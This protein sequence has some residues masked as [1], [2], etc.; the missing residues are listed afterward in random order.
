MGVVCGLTVGLNS[1]LQR[2]VVYC[3]GDRGGRAGLGK[4]EEF[5]F[6][7]AKYERL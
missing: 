3:G 4:A 5:S 6:K 2:E 1:W 7:Y